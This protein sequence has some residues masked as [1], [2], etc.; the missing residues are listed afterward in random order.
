M[1]NVLYNLLLSL[2][3]T[4]WMVVLYG[5]KEKWSIGALST[6]M[7]GILLLIVP[8]ILSGISL[9]I[10]RML[11][12]DSLREC[13]EIN[14]ADNEFVPTYLGYFFA[15]LSAPD[16]TTMMFLFGIVFAFTFL[17][18]TQ[19]FNPIYLLFGYHYYHIKTSQGTQLFVIV[20]GRVIRNRKDV[21]F[22]QLKRINDS[23]YI[24]MRRDIS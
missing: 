9:C 16:R 8:V 15:A 5:I 2:S 18:K 1:L 11:G 19:Y 24:V 21:A 22:Q 6:W 12:T 7:V 4:F 20:K 13:E 17:L 14:L 3:A 23:T 10:A